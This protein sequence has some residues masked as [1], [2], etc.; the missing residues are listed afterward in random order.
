MDEAQLDEYFEELR[1][2][3]R[4]P[5][6]LSPTQ[7]DPLFYFVYPPEQTLTVRRLWPGWKSRLINEDGL[8]VEE[9]SLADL[10]WSV[11]DATPMQWAELLELE[12]SFS[13]EAMN[14]A[15][16]DLLV[17]ENTFVRRVAAHVTAE[18]PGTILF[19]LDVELLHPYF[20]TRFIE[21]YLNNKVTIP[22]VF[23]YPGLRVGEYGLRFLGFYPEDSGYR[24][25]VF[26]GLA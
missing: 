26:G 10:L 11:V 24:S 18:C 17:S 14:G 13:T 23:F 8:Q 16:R 2:R 21:S 7:G 15:I 3:I 12:A 25:P 5:G 4:T 6:G 9:L 20:R 22:T 19:L 1:H